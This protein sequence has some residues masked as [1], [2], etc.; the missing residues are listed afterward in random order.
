MVA[1]MLPRW[2][3]IP[4]LLSANS[5]TSFLWEF[6]LEYTHWID[7]NTPNGFLKCTAVLLPC[8]F[9]HIV[10]VSLKLIRSTTPMPFFRPIT[11]ILTLSN[12]HTYAAQMAWLQGRG[13]E[14]ELESVAL[15][16]YKIY[17]PYPLYPLAPVLRCR[18]VG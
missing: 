9:I 11:C 10:R 17:V 4:V 16:F 3:A 18:C 1:V 8:F 5:S 12:Q 2:V 13:A 6:S 15:F 7:K 14:G